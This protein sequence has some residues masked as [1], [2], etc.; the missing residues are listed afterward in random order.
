M[1]NTNFFK[2]LA[3]FSNSVPQ[4]EGRGYFY[5]LVQDECNKNVEL[6]NYKRSNFLFSS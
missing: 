4:P 1:E 2:I 6:I 5:W 3:P